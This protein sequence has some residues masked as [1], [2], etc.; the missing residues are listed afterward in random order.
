MSKIDTNSPGGGIPSIDSDRIQAIQ[1]ACETFAELP[2][3]LVEIAKDNEAL[4]YL[5][6]NIHVICQ[7]S[8]D[9]KF[10]ADNRKTFEYAIR[11]FAFQASFNAD[12]E[13]ADEREQAN[14]IRQ[15]TQQLAEAKEQLRNAEESNSTLLQENKKL[16][17]KVDAAKQ[18]SKDYFDQLTQNNEKVTNIRRE[19]ASQQSQLKAE[20]EQLNDEIQELRDKLKM[21]EFSVTRITNSLNTANEELSS[22]QAELITLKS[23]AEARNQKLKNAQN[24][25]TKLQL[26][27][28]KVEADNQRL[29]TEQNE[30]INQLKELQE[31]VIALGP[32]NLKNLTDENEAYKQTVQKL[33]QFTEQQAPDIIELRRDQANASELLNQQLQLVNQYD[34]R[35]EATMQD[36]NNLVSQN[37]ALNR[38]LEDVTQQ[39][40]DAKGE[41]ERLQDG[42]GVLSVMSRDLQQTMTDRFGDIAT[43]NLPN[44]I[45]GLLEGSTNEELKDQN[46]R[47]IGIIEN[48][49]RF[50]QSAIFRNTIDP[51]LLS[52]DTTSDPLLQE[53]DTR[54][55]M[56]IE[57]ARTRQF[58]QANDLGEL[59]N[60]LSDKDVQ[61]EVSKLQ[62]PSNLRQREAYA[63]IAMQAETSDIIRR[64]A[65]RV[66]SVNQSIIA[67]LGAAGEVINFDGPTDILAATI[68]EKL[69]NFQAFAKKSQLVI[70]GDFDYNNFDDTISFLSKY[71]QSSATILKQIDT[72]LR[73]AVKFEGELADLPFFAVECVTD[74]LKMIA[75]AKEQSIAEMRNQIEQLR[76]ETDEE[77][78]KTTE[79]I[80][81][82][83]QESK[84]KDEIISD[85]QTQLEQAQSRAVDLNNQCRE[86]DAQRQEAEEKL[87]KMLANYNDV[88]ADMEA[89]KAETER[90]REQMNRKQKQFEERL[91]KMIEE[92]R[93]HNSE[94]LQRFEEK[95]KQ[96]EEKLKLEVNSKSQKLQQAKA[97]LK[98]VIET[99]DQAFKQQKEATAVLRQQN[100]EL[101]DRLQIHQGQRPEA[102]MAQGVQGP[103][104]EQ[105]KADLRQV[106]A[107]KNALESKLEQTIANAEHARTIRESYWESQ[108][109]QKEQELS[110]SIQLEQDEQENKIK[111][112]VDKVANALSPFVQQGADAD[113]VV[114][115]A[116][117]LAHR[118]ASVETELENLKKQKLSQP[119]PSRLTDVQRLQQVSTALQE[120]DRWARD[121]YVNVTEGEVPC[122]STK[123]LRYQLGE[124]VLSSIGHRQ[125]IWRLESL[126][127][128]KKALTSNVKIPREKEEKPLKIRSVAVYVIAA[129]RIMRKSGHI[130]SVFN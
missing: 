37:E 47:L 34:A 126:R 61:K 8:G 100:Q 80:A 70:E 73:A 21:S 128:Q 7:G 102:K 50:L 116:S 24:Q 29:Q 45:N 78:E 64:Y 56:L 54:D 63:V 32:E 44:V 4:K 87:Q 10:S 6:E 65:D 62:N 127:A 108:L 26:Q 112:Y 72:D 48:Q 68:A 15:L 101:I 121:L 41:I 39:L 93:Q 122:Q 129:M 33:Q 109:N 111:E 94:D 86:M 90:L 76:K 69:R 125:L 25:T 81:Q 79:H 31:Q 9:I 97:K 30:L 57:M 38:N 89:A 36:C 98:E 17:Q 59:K 52:P 43:G 113:S 27:I 77:R 75:S 67:Q 103:E 119:G 16:Q 99:Y 51:T 130:Q 91:D 105:L 42:G 107:E 96:R 92:E 60:N 106:T 115:E 66:N 84:H 58:I 82:I 117:N 49:L 23:K 118:L 88:E 35:L 19:N 71:I 120:W 1:T 40:N 55:R 95:L 2:P 14:Q 18:E 5:A 11:T 46:K 20:I 13:P 53:G 12:K 114:Q 124:M 123:D 110:R 74:L 83:E 28:Q 3:E 104:L 85:I 22:T